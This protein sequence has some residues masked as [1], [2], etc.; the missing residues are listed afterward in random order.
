M[1][2]SR[3]QF[4]PPPG[5]A[6]SP[7]DQQVYR[8]KPNRLSRSFRQTQ[9]TAELGSPRS[10]KS[11][12]KTPTRTSR[13]GAAAAL[14]ESPHNDSDFQ[15][16]IVWDAG[17]PLPGRPGNKGKTAAAGVVDISEIVSKIAPKHGRPRVAE[18][19]LQQWIGDSATIP[20]T[21]DVRVPKPRKKSPRLAGV[22]DLLKLAKQFDL[23]MF[24]RDEEDADD[25]L[26]KEPSNRNRLAAACGPGAGVQVNLDLHM[27]DDLDFLFDGPTQHVSG[28]I[29]Q[30]SAA[31]PSPL[32]PAAPGDPSSHGPGSEDMSAGDDWDDDDLLN[33]SLVIEMTQNPQNFVALNHCS[34]QNSASSLTPVHIRV[35][36]GEKFDQP[37]KI[38]R[39]RASFKLEPNLNFSFGRKDTWT[40][41]NVDSEPVDK[42]T[43]LSWISSSLGFSIKARS[44][45]RCQLMSEPQLPLFSGAS[46]GSRSAAAASASNTEPIQSFPKEDGGAT[47]SVSDFLDEDLDSFFSTDLVWDDPADDSLLCEVCEDL[48]N[49]TQSRES[50]KTTFPDV[51]VSKERAALQP[52]NRTW[53][54]QTQHPAPAGSS[55]SVSAGVHVKDSFKSSQTKI[56]SGSIISSSSRVQSALAASK[57]QFSFKKPNNPVPAVTN[58]VLSKCSAAEIELKKQQAME[59]R[60]QRLKAAQNLRAAT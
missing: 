45:Q 34:T 27:E 23:N 32:T 5:S 2:R 6:R 57:N 16:D 3:R 1:T 30:V 53:N 24:H 14:S 7:L 59:R 12:L 21:P 47:P 28:T 56:T 22:D 55:A 8:S 9:A 4:V 18:P 42:D 31:Q 40:S 26:L 11:D 50:I 49:Q 10:Q 46:C 20:C 51:Q 43:G 13:S 33:D 48:E 39:Q 52:S 54:K 35:S 44:Q 60:R 15:Q 25:V 37:E 19:T 38:T 36:G 58:K 29:S 41:T 17:S